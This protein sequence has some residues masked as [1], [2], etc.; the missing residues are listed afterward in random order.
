MFRSNSIAFCLKIRARTALYFVASPAS[1]FRSAGNI[2][3]L[4]NE[5]VRN[6]D[7]S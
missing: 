3:T 1:R 2:V 5:D 6:D 4:R 7:D